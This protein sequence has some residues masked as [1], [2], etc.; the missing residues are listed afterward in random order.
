MY[1]DEQNAPWVIE[2]AKR[3]I[4]RRWSILINMEFNITHKPEEG[5]FP[6]FDK[7]F[8]KKTI[9]SKVVYTTDYHEPLLNMG[10]T[11]LKIIT[12]FNKENYNEE[13]SNQEDSDEGFSDIKVSEDFF[14]W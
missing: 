13:I 5:W 7:E 8:N 6:D 11:P 14:K 4:K 12:E 2:E 9:Y 1:L 3:Y 10:L